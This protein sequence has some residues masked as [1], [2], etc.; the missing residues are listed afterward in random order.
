M[1]SAGLAWICFEAINT[2]LLSH[3]FLF[4]NKSILEQTPGTFLR[5]GT[6]GMHLPIRPFDFTVAAIDKTKKRGPGGLIAQRL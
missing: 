2:K 3:A 1:L 6:G 5:P 4:G